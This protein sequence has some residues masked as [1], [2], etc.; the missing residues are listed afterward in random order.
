MACKKKKVSTT[1]A[2]EYLV[3]ERI[4]VNDVF[5]SDN[6]SP[7]LKEANSP[8]LHLTPSQQAVTTCRV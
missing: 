6:I 4:N 2:A 5:K 8:S 1:S 7:L 3:S